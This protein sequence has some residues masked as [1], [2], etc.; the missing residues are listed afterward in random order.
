M[1][2][3]NRCID[4]KEIRIAEEVL[5]QEKLKENGSYNK[6]E[7]LEAL[8][9]V[10]CRK[11]YIC[12][13]NNISS[14]QIE[15]LKA[16]RGDKEL[17]F[18]WN[19]LFLSCA[20]C[21]NIK[22]GNY[23]NILNCTQVDVDKVISFRVLGGG[24]IFE[25]KIEVKPLNTSPEIINTVELINIVY[26]GNTPQKILECV[27]IKK[28]LNEEV[29]RFIQYLRDYN[30]ASGIEKEDIKLLIKLKLK[31]SSPFAAFKRWVIRDYK[32]SLHDLYE[33]VA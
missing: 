25:N 17:K 13:N 20:H 28:E 9:T 32:D 5:E 31:E 7:V 30:E 26:N 10:F 11:C 8:K 22:L 21:N 6:Q 4:Y 2:K 29:G 16:H 3:Y 23:D 12:E 18:D 27:N 1:V 24:V 15:H 33:Y 14:Y 19:N